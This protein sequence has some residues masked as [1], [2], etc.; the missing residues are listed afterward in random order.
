MGKALPGTI[1]G[2]LPPPGDVVVMMKGVLWAKDVVSGYGCLRASLPRVVIITSGSVDDEEVALDKV[3]EGLFDG[4]VVKLVTEPVDEGVRLGF[5][6]VD[7]GKGFIIAEVA[8]PGA[9]G[10]QARSFVD[11]KVLT[12]VDDSEEVVAGNAVVGV[13]LVL[14]ALEDVDELF[15]VVDGTSNVVLVELKG[16]TC[17]VVDL[18]TVDGFL[19]EDRADVVFRHP[20]DAN[21]ELFVDEIGSPFVV[22]TGFVGL[23]VVNPH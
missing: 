1:V 13:K 12:F 17:V 15:A 14:V 2:S 22:E 9:V 23:V 7:D 6:V 16:G 10:V 8:F 20:E 19:V 3:D 5:L 4:V 11:D 18:A 21:A